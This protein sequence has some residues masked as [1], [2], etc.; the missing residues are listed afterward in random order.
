MYGTQDYNISKQKAEKFSQALDHEG[1]AIGVITNYFNN[2]DVFRSEFLH[3][4]SEDGNKSFSF[5]RRGM[6]SVNGLNSLQSIRAKLGVEQIAAQ[7]EIISALV[8]VFVIIVLIVIAMLVS[9]RIKSAGKQIGTLK[10]MGMT[11]KSISSAYIIFPF[12]I[13]FLGFVFAAILSIPVAL[14]LI[15]LMKSF[16]YVSFAANPISLAFFVKLFF[17]PLVL[18]IGLT[19][20]IS[21][22]TLKK[23][24]LDLLNNID[25]NAPNIFVRALGYVTPVK[26]PFVITYTSKGF[27]RAI[28]KSTLLFFSIFISAFLVAFAMSSTTMLKKQTEAALRYLNVK[29]ISKDSL[30]NV[31]Q[32]K[33]R[34]LYHYDDPSKTWVKTYDHEGEHPIDIAFPW[35]N[36]K[37]IIPGIKTEA[38][39]NDFF[40]YLETTLP[41]KNEILFSYDGT[42]MSDDIRNPNLWK[43][44]DPWKSNYYFTKN[45]M[46]L[47]SLS[48][49][50]AEQNTNFRNWEETRKNK[51]GLTFAKIYPMIYSWNSTLYGNIIFDNQTIP[52]IP[53]NPTPEDIQNLIKLIE[54][55]GTDLTLN[56]QYYNQFQQYSSGRIYINSYKGAINYN[57][58]YN[59]EETKPSVINIT[60]LAVQDSLETLRNVFG[61]KGTNIGEKQYAKFKPYDDKLKKLETAKKLDFIPV[62]LSTQAKAAL[63][64]ELGKG[65]VIKSSENG[66]DTYLVS[67]RANLI[68]GA[69]PHS[70]KNEWDYFWTSYKYRVLVKLGVLDSFFTGIDMGATTTKDFVNNYF[71]YYRLHNFENQV[72]D[73]TDSSGPH[74]ELIYDASNGYLINYNHEKT[75]ITG[76]FQVR[77]D[78]QGK[79]KDET[80]GMYQDFAGNIQKLIYSKNM[81]S[82]KE[83][84]EVQKNG[85]YHTFPVAA[86]ALHNWRNEPVFDDGT[87]VMWEQKLEYKVSDMFSDDEN[88][89]QEMGLVQ[90]YPITIAQLL[91]QVQIVYKLT[92]AI[93]AVISFFAIFIAGTV[94]IIAMK[95]VIDSSKREVA[96]LKALGYSNAKAT[97]L[98][99]FPYIIII[100]IAFV[101]ALPIAF[102]GLGIVAGLLQTITGNVFTF[103]LS[104]VQW[105]LLT[106][107]ILGIILILLVLTY[108]SFSASKPLEAIQATYE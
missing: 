16:Y 70:K 91:D 102:Y 66:I 27:F 28:G 63:E 106:T 33:T 65:N 26:T 95:E 10:A 59:Y 78:Q 49:L 103:T 74:N 41:S 42:R 4:E 36:L 14:V 94:I 34:Y 12:I 92:I 50:S 81:P 48:Y 1:I 52:K 15:N 68:R 73:Y 8:I 55:Y 75:S 20:L 25:N 31:R 19:Y 9:K 7:E 60:N 32:Y 39:Y 17:I 85:K 35:K 29:S 43:N 47:T 79:D 37:T 11:N 90:G 58:R 38:E 40:N 76:Y 99:L 87:Q 80:E 104:V 44:S 61:A 72:T 100:G 18:G 77:W 53:A 3:S 51:G 96:M 62:I 2:H 93:F 84:E 82:G 56:E 30:K 6:S 97:S 101:I 108:I 24:T 22:K 64:D 46:A 54:R 86:L 98:I 83:A 105:I 88:I 45:W 69:G 107:F 23:P 5:K 89:S 13:I 57:D 71:R 67:A 21:I